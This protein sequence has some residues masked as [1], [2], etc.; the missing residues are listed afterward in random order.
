MKISRFLVSVVVDDLHPNGAA[1]LG[2]DSTLGHKQSFTVQFIGGTNNS[3]IENDATKW[4]KD[5]VDSDGPAA[6]ES[7]AEYAEKQRAFKKRM[8][9]PGYALGAPMVGYSPDAV[10][11]GVT[12]FERKAGDGHT[13][14][15]NEHI[16]VDSG[17]T[18]VPPSDA[19]L[20]NA[21]VLFGVSTLAG[22]QLGIHK[23]EFMNCMALSLRAQN[24]LDKGFGLDSLRYLPAY[25]DLPADNINANINASWER[26]ILDHE[27]WLADN[28][29]VLN[30]SDSNHS[31]P[32]LE[33]F[34]KVFREDVFQDGSND[35]T[36]L[37]QDCAGFG[38]VT[39][40]GI[41]FSRDAERNAAKRCPRSCQLPV[42]KSLEVLYTNQGHMGNPQRR[43][44][45]ATVKTD[46]RRVYD[47]AVNN[48]RP[49]VELFFEGFNDAG[50][51]CCQFVADRSDGDTKFTTVSD[52]TT[53]EGCE[54]LCSQDPRCKGYELRT[55][56]NGGCILHFRALHSADASTDCICKAK[57]EVEAVYDE[58]VD[59]YQTVKFVEVDGDV[60]AGTK[61]YSGRSLVLD[62]ESYQVPD[63]DWWGRTPHPREHDTVRRK[64]RIAPRDKS[65]H[66]KGTWCYDEIFYPFKGI[67]AGKQSY[68][69]NGN[70][71]PSELDNMGSNAMWAIATP[72]VGF[73]IAFVIFLPAIEQVVAG[74]S[75][76]AYHS[77]GT[78][79][80]F[81]G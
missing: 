22:C 35:R 37:S 14:M 9:N 52:V 46:Y 1:D 62:S 56:V 25:A 43:I 38:T 3:E 40:N 29:R 79:I 81:H 42:R 39:G 54:L 53:Q 2:L 20:A 48:N 61:E 71:N 36:P 77:G 23:S 55:N 57:R 13:G 15:C 49:N 69:I 45:G 72:A 24:T 75:L 66:C 18:T 58:K 67:W 76:G 17:N 59:M 47:T 50:A 26:S 65:A 32:G 63:Q 4:W 10:E 78:P 34:V 74:G 41:P 80:S 28:S 33:Y 64:Q 30:G 5:T 51:G 11:V 8:G 70:R 27:E 6:D 12:T 19:P 68:G 44:I 21:P 60:L 7:D 73:L 31:A 16:S